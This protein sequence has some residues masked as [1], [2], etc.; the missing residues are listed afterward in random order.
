[1]WPKMEGSSRKRKEGRGKGGG[2]RR[3][4]VNWARTNWDGNAENRTQRKGEQGVSGRA[5][6]ESHP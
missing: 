2:A 6:E 3:A 1:M 4:R 5:W